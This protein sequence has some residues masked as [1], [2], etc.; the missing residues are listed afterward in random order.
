MHS[1]SSF[2]NR[3]A[4]GK[5]SRILCVSFVEG[6]DTVTV[7]KIVDSV[8]DRFRIIGLIC[9]E[10]TFFNGKLSVGF[11]QDIQCNGRIRHICGGGQFADWQSSNTVHQNVILVAPIIL[12]ISLIV[13]I[14]SGMDT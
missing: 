8:V 14:R 3:S 11:L 2:A 6:Y 4:T 1:K 13:L 5:F 10:G 9:D 12:K 7:V